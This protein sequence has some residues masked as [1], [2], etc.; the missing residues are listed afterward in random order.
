[1]VSAIACLTTKSCKFVVTVLLVESDALGAAW[2]RGAEA[3]AETRF[4][5]RDTPGRWPPVL[6]VRLAVCGGGCTNNGTD[7]AGTAANACTGPVTGGGPACVKLEQFR[8]VNTFLGN[9]KTAYSGTYHSFDFAKYA[10]R[11][12][13]EVQYR[14][15]RRFDLSSI[16]K[17]LLVATVGSPPRP[18]RFLRAAEHCG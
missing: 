16:L 7:G 8:A 14:F 3:A 6:R 4:R 1:V 10:H 5:H 13:A 9:L 18:E 11:Y 12:L 2:R 15:N 17:R